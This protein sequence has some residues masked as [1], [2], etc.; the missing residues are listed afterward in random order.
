MTLPAL[1]SR[2]KGADRAVATEDSNTRITLDGK[3]LV[4]LQ[5]QEFL[6]QIGKNWI[7]AVWGSDV[8]VVEAIRLECRRQFGHKA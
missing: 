3:T 5:R 4:N 6:Q 8:D 2:V 1:S 7:T